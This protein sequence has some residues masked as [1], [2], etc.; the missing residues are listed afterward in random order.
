MRP[1]QPGSLSGTVVLL[2]A[3][4]CGACN[5]WHT[6]KPSPVSVVA[7]QPKVRLTLADGSK[8]VVRSPELRGDTL[9]GVRSDGGNVSVPITDVLLIATWGYSAD[10]TAALVVA[11]EL[12]LYITAMAISGCMD[13]CESY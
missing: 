5:A 6:H 7:G 9:F 3:L 4:T 1:R 12:G 8:L 2:L 11:A 13:V 10:R